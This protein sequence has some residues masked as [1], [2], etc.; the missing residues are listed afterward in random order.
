MITTEVAKQ[1]EHVNKLFTVGLSQNPPYKF[2]Q[3]ELIMVFIVAEMKNPNSK[4]KNFLN[5][6]P[7]N[8]DT[9]PEMYTEEELEW[10]KGSP[11]YDETLARKEY[12]KELYA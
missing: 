6:L 9:Y 7:K 11:L 5:T 4:F 8:Y 2:Y 10:T 1:Q 3:Q 12:H